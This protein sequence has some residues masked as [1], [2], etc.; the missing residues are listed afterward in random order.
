MPHI[1][2]VPYSLKYNPVLTLHAHSCAAIMLPFY[3][4][5]SFTVSDAVSV[6]FP[7]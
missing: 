3:T 6:V 7:S 1:K 4:H 2:F 5:I